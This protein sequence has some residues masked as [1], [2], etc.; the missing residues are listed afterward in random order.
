[1]RLL[2]LIV[3]ALVVVVAVGAAFAHPAEDTYGE[4]G[5][6]KAPS[7]AVTIL[8]LERDNGRM[9]YEPNGITA[10]VGEQI[11][12]ILK[13][14]GE[15]PHEFVLGTDRTIRE[16]AEMMKEMPDMAHDDPNAKQVPP[17]GEDELVWR[18]THAG[19]F[20]FACLIPGHMESGMLGSVTVK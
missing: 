15:L 18:F 4:P 3:A 10:R 12:F 7:R 9:A 17:G 2:N 8:M 6:P 1:M 13:N 20:D 19:T 5:D 11:R 14:H 16:H